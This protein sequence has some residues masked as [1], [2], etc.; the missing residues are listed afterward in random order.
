MGSTAL[1]N[2][3]STN[4]KDKD[5]STNANVCANRQKFNM[6]S[7]CSQVVPPY[8]GRFANQAAAAFF[9]NSEKHEVT[10]KTI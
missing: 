7:D 6:R 10:W 3:M 9:R 1:K 2:N 8:G 4:G 5:S